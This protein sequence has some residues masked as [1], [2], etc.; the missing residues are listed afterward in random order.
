MQ[1]RQKL[2]TWSNHYLSW[3]RQDNFPVQ[4]VRY[5]D[6]IND[7]FA[8]F[9]SAAK[10]CGLAFSDGEIQEAIRKCSFAELQKQEKERGFREKSPDSQSFFRKGKAGSWKEELPEYLADMIVHDHRN[11]MERL[12]YL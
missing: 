5:E 10:F 8:T 9:V 11:V 3:T 6:M 1:L 4:V 2:L 12:G 7:S